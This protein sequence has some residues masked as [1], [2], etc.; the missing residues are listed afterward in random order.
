MKIEVDRKPL[1]RALTAA[2]AILERRNVIP[3]MSNVYLSAT[4]HGLLVKASDMDIETSDLIA[5]NAARGGATTV[6]GSTFLDIVRQLPEGALISLE[7]KDGALLVK[8]GRAKFTLSTLP[9]EDFPIM[10]NDSFQSNFRMEAEAFLS[11]LDRARPCMSSDEVKYY[12]NGV[13]LHRIGPDLLAVSTDGHRLA[14]VAMTAPEGSE[15]MP[16]IIVPR[17]MVD[18]LGAVLKGVKG[19]VVLSVS[20]TKMRMDT[21]TISVTSKVID[22]NFPDYSR[23]IPPEQPH[24]IAFDTSDLRSAVTRAASVLEGKSSGTKL[25]V[26]QDACRVFARGPSHQAEDEIPAGY[27]GPELIFGF[28]G[29]Y[30]SELLAHIGEACTLGV[31]DGTSA[32]TITD[33]GSPDLTYVLMPLRVA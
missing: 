7:E 15:G 26:T 31:T 21:E 28:N 5:C 27:D 18:R 25:T 16:G 1:L 4:K 17:K 29:K 33:S 23:V 10:A 11:L 20:D 30:M 22:G 13:Y 9:A 19:D 14:R 8:A 2:H 24:R 3:I 32:V 12:L 6:P